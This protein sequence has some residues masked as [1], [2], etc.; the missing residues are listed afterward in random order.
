MFNGAVPRGFTVGIYL[1]GILESVEKDKES[2]AASNSVKS[3]FLSFDWIWIG[4]PE[5]LHFKKFLNQRCSESSFQK[6]KTANR[7]F[8]LV[9][10]K[11]RQTYKGRQAPSL[12]RNISW[13][14]GYAGFCHYSKWDTAITSLQAMGQSC[15]G[16]ISLCRKL[17]S[18]SNSILSIHTYSSRWRTEP[19]VVARVPFRYHAR[20]LVTARNLRKCPERL[21]KLTHVQRTCM[22]NLVLLVREV[23]TTFHWN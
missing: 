19:W 16:K 8:H 2:P 23:I 5:H 22:Y 11:G 9:K 14:A 3:S 21:K 4:G 20:P 6:E 17:I 18:Y 12:I 1:S 7:K 15:F 10:T 13:S